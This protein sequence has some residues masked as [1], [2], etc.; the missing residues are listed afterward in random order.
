MISSP[1]LLLLTFLVLVEHMVAIPT[2]VQTLSSRLYNEHA[3]DIF[4]CLSSR[5]ALVLGGF[6]PGYTELQ[7]VEVV[8][9]INL[10]ASLHTECQRLWPIKND[11]LPFVIIFSIITATPVLSCQ[12]LWNT[13]QL[14]LGLWRQFLQHLQGLQSQWGGGVFLHMLQ[15]YCQVS[16][17]C[18]RTGWVCRW[19]GDSSSILFWNRNVKISSFSCWPWR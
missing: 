12:R 4:D 19:Q 17:R 16:W 8:D 5:Y 14:A 6:G 2:I 3:L 7:E 11:I 9:T 13:A 1:L 10:R 18:V 15:H